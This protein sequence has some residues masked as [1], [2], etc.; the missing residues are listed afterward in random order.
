MSYK[1]ELQS[2]NLDLQNILEAL[3]TLPS[4]SELINE[5]NLDVT[6]HA[7]IRTTLNDKAT[8]ELYTATALSTASLWTSSNGYYTLQVS[9]PGILS[10]DTPIVGVKYINNNA[11]NET[12]DEEFLKII[13]I[14]TL[15]NVIKF[16][17]KEIPSISIPIQLKVVR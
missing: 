13:R 6:T 2:N 7:D 3:K 8:T 5:H 14:E 10:T 17:A 4:V 9:V 15:D 16:H 12:Y 11:T 1:N